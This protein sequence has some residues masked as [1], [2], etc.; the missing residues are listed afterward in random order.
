MPLSTIDSTPALI[1]IDLQK[2]VLGLPTVHPVQEVVERTA[3]LARAFRRHGLPVVLVNVTGGAPG[4]TEA[5][6][7]ITDR[8]ADW[9]ELADELDPQPDDY[10]VTK[11]RWGAFHGT[12]LDEYLRDRGVTQVVMTG[13]ATSFGVES[14]ARSA[15]EHGY[16][17]VLATDAITDRDPAAHQNSI[18]RIFPRLGETATT[19]EIIEMLEQSHA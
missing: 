12:S 10:R 11:E 19:A 6:R 2:G 3:S 16:H 5:G 13:V 17:V 9:A 8:P 15:H 14:T 4:R 1:V 18:E 7:P